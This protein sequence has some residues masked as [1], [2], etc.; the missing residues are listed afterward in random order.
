MFL[1]AIT[2]IILTQPRPCKGGKSQSVVDHAQD[3]QVLGHALYLVKHRGVGREDRA[4]SHELVDK[5]LFLTKK[6]IDLAIICQT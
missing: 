4:V 5:N 1:H 2:G 6:Y 3:L